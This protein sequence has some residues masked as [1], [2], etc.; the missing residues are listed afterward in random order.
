MRP[1]STGDNKA[2][3]CTSTV[4][5]PP[6]EKKKKLP[7][8][9]LGKAA[10]S[11]EMRRAR[12]ARPLRCLPTATARCDGREAAR[13]DDR[14]QWPVV[15]VVPHQADVC[16]HTVAHRSWC[17]D[18]WPLSP[19]D[20][21]Q[22]TCD[23]RLPLV[24]RRCIHAATDTV[25]RRPHGR[26][27]GDRL[28]R[29]DHLARAGP[30]PANFACCTHLHP[31]CSG[32]PA[33]HAYLGSA[34]ASRACSL[35]RSAAGMYSVTVIDRRHSGYAWIPV[36]TVGTPGFSSAQWVILDPRRGSRSTLLIIFDPFSAF[37]RSAFR[38]CSIVFSIHAIRVLLDP[39]RG[40]P[41]KLGVR[42]TV[43]HI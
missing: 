32:S 36:G 9:S 41:S 3:R 29:L 14:F 37:V 20:E 13:S 21:D 35:S 33:S 38:V 26:L 6:P 42:G 22:N 15:Q 25:V 27:P 5:P 39:R 19:P 23:R 11:A 31:F 28:A 17:P 30:N 43:Y 24:W 2:T 34:S 4:N 16:A 7:Q 40:F 10:L 1:G 12:V 8:K 18:T